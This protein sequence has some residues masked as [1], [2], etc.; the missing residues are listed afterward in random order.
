[1]VNS[2][3][4]SCLAGLG[5]LATVACGSSGDDG[6]GGGDSAGSAWDTESP[7]DETKSTHLWVVNRGLDILA[8]HTAEVK[9]ASN[10]LAW[11]NDE[12]CRASWQDGLFQADFLAPF[13]AAGSDLALPT[14][15]APPT[16]LEAVEGDFEVAASHASWMSHFYDPDTGK[17]YEG[18]AQSSD[19]S[20][21]AL[22][23]PV[24]TAIKAKVEVNGPVPIEAKGSTIY[25]IGRA[26]DLL[27][28]KTHP[29]DHPNEPKD[30][31]LRGCYELGLA[32][33]Y[34]TDITQPMH[35][36]NFAATDRPRLLHSNWE[37]WA[38][39]LQSKFVR[40][41]WS[42]APSGALADV[43]QAAAV[44]SK[45]HWKGADGNDGPLF[46][47]ILDAYKKGA[48]FDASGAP[49]ADAACVTAAG[50]LAVASFV[51]VDLAKCWENDKTVVKETGSALGD[52]Q[53]LTA[54][55]LATLDLP[56]HKN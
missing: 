30:L 24:F 52:A 32:L 41:D 42:K 46:A 37:G 51:S 8:K 10:T 31:R 2:F 40:A 33:H 28:G 55:F 19:L 50:E 20:D 12:Q 4:V 15:D 27:A 53:E 14:D 43:I 45:A 54:R 6:S 49:S 21:D 23:H 44:E 1:M 39:T 56:P 13:N 5:L 48:T 47:A 35:S 7:N 3:R 11:M 38:E 16:N 26:V 29:A 36:A 18:L 25:R 34:F 22:A 9:G 17:N